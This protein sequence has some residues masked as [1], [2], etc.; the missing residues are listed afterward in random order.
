MQE[1]SARNDEKPFSVTFALTI[2]QVRGGPP[3]CLALSQILPLAM[4]K[5]S[6][7]PALTPPTRRSPPSVSPNAL[8]NGIV[9]VRPPGSSFAPVSTNAAKQTAPTNATAASLRIT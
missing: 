8:S 7:E 5:L 2:A 3:W 4:S 1:A 6:V 9:I